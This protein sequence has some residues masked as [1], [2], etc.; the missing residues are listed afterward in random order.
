MGHLFKNVIFTERFYPF[1]S[2]IL[3][4]F[5][6]VTKNCGVIRKTNLTCLENYPIPNNYWQSNLL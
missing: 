6:N 1:K 2:I 4:P 3:S 5:E